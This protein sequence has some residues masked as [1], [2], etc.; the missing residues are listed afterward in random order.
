MIGPKDSEAL[1]WFRQGEKGMALERIPLG[2][3]FDVRK[4]VPGGKL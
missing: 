1:Y 2:T 3:K 4:I